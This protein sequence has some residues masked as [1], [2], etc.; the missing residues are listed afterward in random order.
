MTITFR[1]SMCFSLVFIRAFSHGCRD[2]AVEVDGGAGDV[3]RA[4]RGEERDQIGEL[5]RLAEAPERQLAPLR[6]LLVVLLDVALRAPLVLRRL[7]Q[8]EADRVDQDPVGGQLVGE[9]LGEIYARRARDAGRQ[10][11]RYRRL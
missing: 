6:N 4:L 11:A 10:G 3:G 8:A 7:H 5:A 1:F 9:R 2:T